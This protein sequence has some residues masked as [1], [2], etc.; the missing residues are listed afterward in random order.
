MAAMV[1]RPKTRRETPVLVDAA[2]VKNKIGSSDV[3]VVDASLKM[4][5][6]PDRRFRMLSFEEEW[7]SA[8][9]PG[10]TYFNA[11]TDGSL[12]GYPLP[13]SLLSATD[14]ATSASVRGISSSSHIV[15]YSRTD[16]IWAARSWWL[17]RYYGAERV[18]VLDG[19]WK[20]WLAAGFPTETCPMVSGLG[21]FD[22]RLRRALLANKSDVLAALDENTALCVNA[23]SEKSF[24]GESAI[25]FGRPG[26]IAGSVNLPVDDLIDH[27]SGRILG[28]DKIWAALVQRNIGTDRRLITYC[29]G[30]IS[31]SLLGLVLE[32]A[33]IDDWSLYDASL[34]EWARDPNLPMSRG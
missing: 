11:Y 3:C 2:W 13:F 9:I 28:P 7:Q 21:L 20:S 15:V 4:V 19:G 12:L 26:R 24:R 6:D 10:S 27:G 25:H 34:S 14:F 30:G 32:S 22:A 29:G 23:L 5:R 17:F 18:S 1:N 16:V 8:R 33:G 31:A